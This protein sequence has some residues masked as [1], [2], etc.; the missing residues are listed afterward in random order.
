M[1]NYLGFP[2]LQGRIKKVDFN[3]FL[4]KLKAR[5]SGWKVK[6]LNKAGRVTL[7]RSILTTMP[8]YNMQTHK[9]T[10]GNL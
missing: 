9:L 7:A 2:L 10:T 8:L 5:L 3:F 6:L 1:G 4:D